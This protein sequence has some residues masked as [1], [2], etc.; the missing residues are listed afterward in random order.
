MHDLKYIMLLK[1]M[2]H[3]FLCCVLTSVGRQ[4]YCHNIIVPRDCLRESDAY[5]Y[6]AIM[7][8]VH[9]AAN[10]HRARRKVLVM[11]LFELANFRQ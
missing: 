8:S 4:R 3:G 7:N 6:V 9:V 1:K 11:D 2:A 10:L 5:F